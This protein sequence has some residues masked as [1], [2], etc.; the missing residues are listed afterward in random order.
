MY[1]FLGWNKFFTQ[2]KQARVLNLIGA[3][4]TGKT[5][6][7]VALSWHL[8]RLGYVE[9]AA[10]NFPCDISSAPTYR[11]CVSVL[12]EAALIFDARNAFKS[13]QLNKL[14]A[15]L[16]F[17]LRKT[18]SYMLVP[19]FIDVDRRLRTGV[20]IYRKT[21]VNNRLWVYHW[22]FGPEE[23]EERRPGLNFFEGSLML[24]NPQYF[25]GTYDTYFVPGPNLSLDFCGRLLSTN[26]QEDLMS[27]AAK[28]V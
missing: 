26:Y 8:L 9:R 14:L 20:R 7:S 17:K 2:L 22:E 23:P 12:D 10:M 18:G 16:T 19:S 5:L 25:F 3:M 13:K 15:A 1:Y 11:Y 21:A 27:K 4:G 28:D 24:V 6:F